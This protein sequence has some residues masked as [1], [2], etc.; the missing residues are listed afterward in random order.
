[1][2]KPTINEILAA[3]LRRLMSDKNLTQ[4]ALE[5]LSGVRQTTISLYLTPGRRQDSISGKAPSAKLGEVD[6]LAGALGVQA[7]EMVR[8]WGVGQHAAY[9]QI[10]AAYHALHPEKDELPGDEI[11]RKSG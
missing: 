2:E 3:N 6:S 1:M 7:W 11:K 4:K 5:K 10:E 8:E 9:K